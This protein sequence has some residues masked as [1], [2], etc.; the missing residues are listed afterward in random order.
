MTLLCAG[1]CHAA[2]WS[3]TLLEQADAPAL[4]RNQLERAYLGHPGGSTKAALGLGLEDA[5]FE[6]QASQSSVKLQSEAVASQE[7]AR[8]SA[9]KAEKG[10]AQALLV[11]LPGD[12]AAAVASSV[13][14]A[15]IN[16]SARDQALRESGC[17]PNL[18]HATASERMRA[19]A[20]AQALASRKWSQVL[21]LT[22]PGADDAKR[23]QVAQEAIQRYGLKLVASKAF[24]VSADPRERAQANPLL[25]TAGINYNVVWVVDSEGD[26]A[27]ALPF[28]TSLPRP[29]VGDGGLVALG[30][31][32]QF[33]R[34][35]GPQVSRRFAKAAQRPMTD[36]DWAAWAAGHALAAAVIGLKAADAQA[37]RQALGTVSFDGGKGVSQQF[38]PWDRQLRQPLLLSDGQGVVAMAPVDGILHPRNTLDTLGADEPEKRCKAKP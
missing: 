27:R 12:W 19:D 23:G 24:K 11:D 30:W 5:Q 9:I 38:R 33:E 34:Y 8:A 16:L 25:L 28:N 36:P 13:R 3:V 29:V 14:V 21:L 6:L 18:F 37:L 22:G 1:A 10:G 35:G 4:E 17:L 7:A 2:N 15:V 20:L 26:F 32:N 31:H